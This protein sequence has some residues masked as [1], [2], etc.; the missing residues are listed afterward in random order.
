M[1][2]EYMI[3]RQLVKLG[4]KKE[5]EPEKP[6]PIKKANAAKKKENRKLKKA[7][8]IYLAKPENQLCNIRIDEGCTIEATVVN[9]TRRRG[10]N[11]FNEK[12]WEPSCVN[13]NTAIE[14]KDAWARANGHLK[15][16][17]NNK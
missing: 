1:L 7:Y 15:S 12:D 16:K 11:V 3:N 5:T 4:I 14:N 2:S 9:H 10:K 6:K 13:C 8:A 17:F